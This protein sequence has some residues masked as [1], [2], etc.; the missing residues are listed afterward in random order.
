MQNG[1]VV[2]RL[3]GAAA[4]PAP[5]AQPPA[6]PGEHMKEVFDHFRAS[7]EDEF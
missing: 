5:E 1:A 3:T 7:I 4:P 2:G 6:E